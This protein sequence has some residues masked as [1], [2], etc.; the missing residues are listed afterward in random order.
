MVGHP[1]M[2]GTEEY[3][4]KIGYPQK[5]RKSYMGEAKFPRMPRGFEK[6]PMPKIE[7]FAD[8]Q[9]E[10]SQEDIFI[11]LSVLVLMNQVRK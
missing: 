8:A 1:V 7:V 10:A 6:V 5:P 11:L 2:F 4:T 3:G 9:L